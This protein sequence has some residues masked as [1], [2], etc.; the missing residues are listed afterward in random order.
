MLTGAPVSHTRVDALDERLVLVA[1]AR[2]VGPSSLANRDRKRKI[3][4]NL[5]RS[6]NTE[7]KE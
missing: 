1:A 5:P 4:K 2:N 6:P 7:R 3:R